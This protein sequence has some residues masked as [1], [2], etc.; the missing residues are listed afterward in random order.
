VSDE[1][2]PWEPAT[3][4]G[5][6]ALFAGAPFRWWISGARALELHLGSGW[7]EHGDT[8]VGICRADATARTP[9]WPRGSTSPSSPPVDSPWDGRPLATKE[10]NVW[11]RQDP[12]G[13]WVFDMM[14]GGGDVSSWVYR[15]DPRVRRPWPAAVLST[16]DGVPYL[17]P[18]IQLLF[19]S[20]GLRDKDHLDATRVI[21]TLQPDR[22]RWLKDTLPPTHPWQEL[23]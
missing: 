9:S 20:K 22:R 8:D 12:D 6:A 11:V 15:R 18:E 10:D 14:I 16:T 19:K 5:I 3:I 13:P 21:P 2:G 17:A 23:M 1:Y 4:E 7:R